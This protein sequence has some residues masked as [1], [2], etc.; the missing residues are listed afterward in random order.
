MNLSPEAQKLLEKNKARIVIKEGWFWNCL[1]YIVM[2]ITF[3]GNK[4][5][6]TRF[7]T[8][9]GPM[10]GV[11]NHWVGTPS[12]TRR[13][14]T[15]RHELVHVGQFK[16]C[17]LGNAWL[18][19][20]IMF[21]IYV[22]LPFPMGIAWGRWVLERRAYLENLRIMKERYGVYAAEVEASRI[23]DMLT[24]GGYGWTLIPFG[25]VK[26]YCKNWLLTNI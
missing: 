16:K 5:F 6:K 12:T 15:I 22:M 14:A 4:S 9:I 26:R 10:I 1:H 8:T 2:I 20:P 7:V 23:V 17:G 13:T 18:G 3:G 11:P 21:L 24:G 19:L 25:F